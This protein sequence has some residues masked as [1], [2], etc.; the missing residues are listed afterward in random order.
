MI[1]IFDDNL[2]RVAIKYAA[3]LKVKVTQTTLR[4]KLEQNPYYPS[5]YSLS[6][7][8]QH[9]GIENQAFHLPANEFDQ[10]EAPFLAFI[11]QAQAASNFVLVTALDAEQVDYVTAANRRHQVTRQQFLNDY[12]QIVFI[13]E[14]NE[15]AGEENYEIKRAAEKKATLKQATLFSGAILIF[16]LALGSLIPQI[17]SRSEGWLTLGT[18]SL[19][20]VAKLVGVTAAVLLL[21]YEI[22]KSNR[23]VK[24][25]CTA[26]KQT[27]CD[28]VLNSEAA[29]IAG[30]SWSEIGFFYFTSTLLFLFVPG[31]TLQ[32]KASI[33]AFAALPASPYIFFSLYYQWKVVRHWCPLCIAAQVALAL[34]LFWSIFY[35]A[36]SNGTNHYEISAITLGVV[37]LL[38]P[39]VAW[40]LLKPVFLKARDASTYKASY[41]RLL[42]NPET[43]NALLVQQPSAP[44]GFQ[45]LGILIGNPNAAHT[46]VKVCN[47]YC[48]PCAKAHHVLAEIV[49]RNADY[50]LRIIFTATNRENDTRTMA[51]KHLL[52][53]AAKGETKETVQAVDDWYSAEQKNYEKFALRY[54]MNGELKQQDAKIEAMDKWCQDA[55]ITY[56]PT[57]YVQGKRL[58]D[59]YR[60]E[61]LKNIL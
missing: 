56:T 7:V 37:C 39:P 19:I 54:P 47:P 10:L 40:F 46:I 27:N 38:A 33:L 42:Y 13:A 43:F 25:I 58:P 49:T 2:S 9:Y 50:N 20:I 5:L 11:S 53:V 17:L 59:T 55:A 8:F 3:L 36:S 14:G 26:G 4:E 51:V 31:V 41:K 6:E 35:Y 21:V 22:D 24:S 44:D 18:V 32:A 29:K 45:N 52:S 16:V 61:E 15:T 57:I 23:F 1:E 30:V 60:V 28:A 48:A 34:E 12:R